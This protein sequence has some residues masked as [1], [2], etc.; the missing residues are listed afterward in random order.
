MK[1]SIITVSRNSSGTIRDTLQ[2]VAMQTY[3]DVEHL[4]IDGASTDATLDIVK[5]HGSRVTTL[6]SEKDNGIYD[7]MNKGL[8]LATGDFVGFL[9]AD[10]CF[11]QADSVARIAAAAET[12]QVDAV[13]GDLLYVLKDRPEQAIRYWRSG[14]FSP[15]RL[16]FGWMPPHPTLYIRR[17]RIARHGVFDSRL[18]ISAD[19][20]FALRYLKLAGLG[21][22]YVPTVLVRMRTGGAS[23]RSLA[24]LLNKSRE[25][26]QALRQN[27]V[28]GLF[29]LM[30]KNVRKLPQFFSRPRLS[31]RAGSTES[32]GPF[33]W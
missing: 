26:L 1:I 31:H 15:S 22:A 16:R 23:N 19:Y 18:R 28:G 30:S 4:I 24:A 9:N 27:E 32:P 10:D 29:S 13:Y 5:A 12:P 20:D 21:V 17:S 3:H 14:A 8:R 25:D 2:S 6:V 11:A 33:H 7:A